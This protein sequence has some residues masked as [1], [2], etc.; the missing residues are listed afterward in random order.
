[1]NKDQQLKQILFQLSVIPEGCNSVAWKSEVGL[2]KICE[3]ENNFR[4]LYLINASRS[5][6][7]WGNKTCFFNKLIL[8][9][10]IFLCN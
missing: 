3:N 1:M 2:G 7:R 9:D 6:P 8:W 4:A 10:V 5:Q